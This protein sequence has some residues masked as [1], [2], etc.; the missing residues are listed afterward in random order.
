M[1]FISIFII[2]SNPTVYAIL[3]AT[4]TVPVGTSQRIEQTHNWATLF[5]REINTGTWPSRLGGV[6]KIE[7]IKYALESC[8]AQT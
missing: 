6:S 3:H 1:T 8:G 7:T 5:L 4:V 2:A